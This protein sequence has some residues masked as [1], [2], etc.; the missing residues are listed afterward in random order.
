MEGM[1]VITNQEILE[2]KQNHPDQDTGK[3]IIP[4]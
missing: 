3:I 4:L 1:K 2:I